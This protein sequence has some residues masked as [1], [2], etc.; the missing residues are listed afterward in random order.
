MKKKYI[1]HSITFSTLKP[2]EYYTT[3]EAY[4]LQFATAMAKKMCRENEQVLVS[5]TEK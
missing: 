4:N 1:F 3:I 5:I 2:T